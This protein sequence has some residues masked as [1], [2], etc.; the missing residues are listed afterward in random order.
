VS[1]TVRPAIEPWGVIVA[2]F[3]EKIKR[4]RLK[5]IA[6]YVPSGNKYHVKLQVVTASGDALFSGKK[7]SILC[8][9]LHT[10]TFSPDV[11]LDK[12]LSRGQGGKYPLSAWTRRRSFLVTGRNMIMN[13]KL[14]HFK[15]AGS[16]YMKACHK[17]K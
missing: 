17:S 8:R 12:I 16:H 7:S 3:G 4:F 5:A 10:K 2:L 1:L 15:G 13:R 9:Y 11:V 14:L 6:D